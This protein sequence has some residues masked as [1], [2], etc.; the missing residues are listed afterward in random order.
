MDGAIGATAVGVIAT[1]AG[2]IMATAATDISIM[3]GMA[4]DMAMDMAV[5]IGD[6]GA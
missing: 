3:A 5:I 2:V 4:T 1:A 6:I